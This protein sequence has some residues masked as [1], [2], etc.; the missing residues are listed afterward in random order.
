MEANNSKLLT[1]KAVEIYG[2]LGKSLC[3]CAGG[4]IGF[5]LGGPL[6][7]IPGILVGAIAGNVLEKNLSLSIS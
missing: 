2:L 5:V 3:G 1:K 4:I 7:G 6:L